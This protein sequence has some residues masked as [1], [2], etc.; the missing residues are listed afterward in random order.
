[1]TVTSNCSAVTTV[2]F[3]LAVNDEQYI[4]TAYINLQGTVDCNITKGKMYMPNG[5]PGYL[6]EEEYD[7]PCWND[8]DFDNSKGEYHGIDLSSH[9]HMTVADN[10]LDEIFEQLIDFINNSWSEITCNINDFEVV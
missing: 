7:E 6:D 5:D 1:M 8:F 2:P 4:G 10:I 3:S 9:S